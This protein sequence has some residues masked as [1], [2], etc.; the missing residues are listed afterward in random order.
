MDFIVGLARI[1]D[2]VS[3]FPSSSHILASFHH[4]FSYHFHPIASGGM[5]VV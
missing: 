4:A 3:I 2:L 1:L 5:I